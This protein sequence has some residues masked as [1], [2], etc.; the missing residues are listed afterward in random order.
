[1]QP[2][3]PPEHPLIIARTQV[4]LPKG[5][6]IR[7]L[8]FAVDEA[9]RFRVD[10]MVMCAEIMASAYV[11]M[12]E[13]ALRSKWEEKHNEELRSGHLDI[14]MF[15][16]AWSM[17]DQIYSLRLLLRSLA[18]SGDEMNAFMSA[19]MSAHVLRNRT[20]HLDQLIPNIAASKDN[21]RSLFGSL[22]YFVL[23]AAVGAPEIDAF[24]VAQHADP[25][26][27]NEQIAAIRMPK[28][29]RMPIGNFVLTAAGEELDLDAAILTIGPVMT[30][31]NE[32]IE[33]S[34]RAQAAEK[35]VEHGIE[36]S[37]LLVHYG[38]RLKYMFAMKVGHPT[39]QSDP[40]RRRQSGKVNE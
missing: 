19:T 20:D 25:V 23:G 40:A 27:P 21:S 37:A 8:P 1:M 9:Q 34:I 15:Q 24:A 33:K 31:T 32:G 22:S 4:A 2:Q 28:E 38:A 36:Q 11:Q 3:F 30:R 18:F 35:A 39:V 26:R 16:H 14:A 5:A 6:F 12:I 10:A 29:L 7:A 17:V 13:L